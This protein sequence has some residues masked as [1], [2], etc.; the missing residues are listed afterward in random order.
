[1]QTNPEKSN[2]ATSEPS[3]EMPSIQIKPEPEEVECTVVSGLLCVCG[4]VGGGLGG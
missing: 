2:V 3:K 1:C 4:A